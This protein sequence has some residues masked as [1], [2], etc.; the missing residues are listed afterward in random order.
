[1]P[2]DGL[3]LPVTVCCE[4]ELIDV[5]EQRLELGD[6]GLFVRRDHVEGLEVV[7]DVDTES[8]PGLTLV[9]GGHVRSAAWEVPDV[10]AGRLHHVVVA[11]IR[12]DL[13]GLGRRLDDHEPAHDTA[14]PAGCC[15]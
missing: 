13:A 6:G 5:L 11:E 9:L 4:I 1:M 12:G 14:S 10:S 8:R 7:L 2:G 15:T 3:A